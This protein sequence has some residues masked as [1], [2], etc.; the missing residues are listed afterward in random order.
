MPDDTE[1]W[2]RICKTEGCR[3]F[4]HPTSNFC[5]KCRADRKGLVP[6]EVFDDGSEHL[7]CK[8][9]G[10]CIKCGDCKEFGCG[11]KNG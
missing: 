10:F 6:D 5:K 11:V 4:A 1:F 3:S 9:C 7:V 2:M 8:D